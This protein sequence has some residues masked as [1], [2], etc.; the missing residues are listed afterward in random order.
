VKPII[1]PSG[2]QFGVSC[3]HIVGSAT[4]DA[5]AGNGHGLGEAGIKREAA[6]DSRHDQ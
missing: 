3:V 5:F 6:A 4:W 2:D 1:R